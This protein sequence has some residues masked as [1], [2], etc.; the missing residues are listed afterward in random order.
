MTT[1]ADAGATLPVGGA[2]T[3]EYA[4]PSLGAD[5]DAGRVV[6]WRMAVGDTVHRGDIVAVVETEKSDI[7]IEIWHDGTV[8]ELLVDLGEEIPVGTP[9][10]RLRAPA[11][12]EAGPA[13]PTGPTVPAP[14][15]LP[16]P[17][18]PAP[19]PPA[20]PSSSAR[21]PASPWARRLAVERGVDLAA[22]RGTGPGGAVV[23]DDVARA[24][25]TGPTAREA[26]VPATTPP[27]SA[28]PAD[29]MRRLIAERMARANR[30]I[31]HYHLARD[32][33]V[34]ALRAWLSATNGDRPVG[35][36][37]LPAAAYVK[38]VAVAA[39]ANPELNG[40]WGEDGFEPGPAVNVAMAI[41]LR[42]GGLV[43]PHVPDA[44][45][46]S[47][48]EIMGLLRTFVAEARTGNLRASWMTGG[49]ITL[50]NLGDHG[51]DAV[52]G[53]ISPPQVAL[54]GTGRTREQPWVVDGEVVV[55]PVVTITLAAD[56]RATDGIRGSRFLD[57]LAGALERPEEL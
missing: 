57:A 28:G 49:T 53:V 14:A 2:G 54:V 19:G 29:P 25:P 9:I 11:D 33:D 21:V 40:F 48:D 20:P 27:A 42:S 8:E 55:R 43:T 51:A 6:E 32:V 18:A 23:A 17:P 13:G 3:F 47:L 31:P 39:A 26:T 35:E 37:L 36:R 10:A 44:D 52:H 24:V 30:E 56:H 34:G 50:T 5:M 46:R 15:T 7:D 12:Q 1:T 38:A 45:Q 16:P 41:S 4:L 22:V